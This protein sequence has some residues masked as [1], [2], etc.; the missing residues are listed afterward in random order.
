[1]RRYT[2]FFTCSAIL[3]GLAFTMLGYQRVA[4]CEPLPLLIGNQLPNADFE[5]DETH[6]LPT[7]WSAAAPGVVLRGP[8]ID[9]QGFDLDGNGRSLQ[10]IGIANAII[11]PA[12]AA[13][14]GRPYCFNARTLTDSISA[15][16]VRANFH[17]YDANGNLLHI[18][19]GPWQ[20]VVRWRI[21]TPPD[22]WT[23]LRAAF[24][25][26]TGTT[27]LIIRI[28]P[29]SDDRIYLDTPAIRG[30]NWPIGAALFQPVAAQPG[31]TTVTLGAWPE[32]RTA[33]LSFSFDWETAMGGLIHSRSV[34]DPY[35]DLDPVLRGMRM[36]EG[37]TTTLDLF[38]PHQIPATYY[39]NGYN[40]LAGNTEQRTFMG[41]P[42]FRWAGRANRWPSDAW[43]TTRWFALDPYGTTA[44]DPAW[45][46]GDLIAPL[47]QAGHD[48]QSHTFSH[49]HGGLASAQEW[50]ADLQEWRVVAAD[51]GVAAA[52]SLAFPWSSSAGMSFDAWE[53][54]AAAGI[55]SVTRTSWNPRQ[56]QFQ[57]VSSADPHCR[58]IPGHEQILACPDFYLTEQSAPQAI[59]VIERTI[60]AGG[61]IDLWAHTEEV[62]TPAQIA[63]WRSVV[64]RAAAERAAGRLWI[65][66][67]AEIADW[68]QARTAVSIQA[69]EHPDQSLHGEVRLSLNNPAT[70]TLTG[71]TLQAPFAI[72]SATINGSPVEATRIRD[73]LLI[74]DLAAGQTAEVT[75]WPA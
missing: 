11:T 68:Q 32:G 18:D 54:L 15:T 14:P 74:I 37:I 6:A 43:A 2:I 72:G 73:Q 51:H 38:A 5:P 28:V 45:Y 49:L 44:T 35:A 67:L 21:D 24:Y 46:F 52:R 17:W 63:A 48:I 30:G 66:P 25:A 31:G 3:I 58:P 59:E 39:A 60:A 9:N 65:A 40:F 75:L 29:A 47:R 57:I 8:A 4:R 56:P 34:D 7:G 70:H 41:D 13:E 62:I 19:H 1:M 33:A 50:R 20:P 53:E 55:T 12:I 10:L 61:M 36:R 22:E 27:T 16:Q 71:L 23:P 69:V 26:P 64:E 42:I